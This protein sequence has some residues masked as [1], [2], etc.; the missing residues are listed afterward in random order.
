MALRASKMISRQPNKPPMTAPTGPQ[1]GPRGLRDAQDGLQDGPG[2]PQE[3]LSR[4]REAPKT[5]SDCVRRARRPSRHP[6]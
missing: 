5:A 6:R 1:H 2:A 3:A 4:P